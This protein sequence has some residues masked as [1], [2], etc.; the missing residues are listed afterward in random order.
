MASAYY[1]DFSKNSR[2]FPT[3]MHDNIGVIAL[4]RLALEYAVGNQ[5]DLNDASRGFP[6]IF[7]V[8]RI[9]VAPFL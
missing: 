3:T 4:T 1:T 9:Q 2:R 7:F 6:H 5:P 8:V